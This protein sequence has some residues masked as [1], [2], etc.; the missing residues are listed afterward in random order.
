MTHPGPEPTTYYMRG[1]HAN[2]LAIQMRHWVQ[3]L[4]VWAMK[5]SWM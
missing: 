2:H 1:M 5:M 4:S 3:I